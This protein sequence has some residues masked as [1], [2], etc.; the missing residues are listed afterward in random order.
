[1]TQLWLK[2]I[3][4]SGR[5]A[6]GDSDRVMTQRELEAGLAKGKI[7]NDAKSVAMIHCVG[8]RD[9]EHLYCSRTCCSETVKNALKVKELNPE[10]EVYCFYRDMRTY[11]KNEDYYRLAREKGVIFVRFDPER[12]PVISPNGKKLTVNFYDFIVGDDVEIEVDL[13]ALAEGAWP[14]VEGNK[15]LAEMLK[16]PLTADGFYLEAHMKLRPVD[17]ATEGV[18][19]CGLAHGPKNVEESI[20]QAQAAAARAITILAKDTI[21]AEGR[22]AQVNENRC[23]GCGTCVSICPYIAI[24]LDTDK[25]IAVVNEGLC[26]GCGS[27]AAACWSAAIDI[28]GV[29]NEQLLEAITAL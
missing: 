8:S 3:W 2:G 1:M 29:S 27:C 26:K 17:F 28:A 21:T 4:T 12:K 23:I 22:V 19:V 25:G 16:V 15:R 18:F 13:L 24:E 10:T 5:F 6:L 20:S 11:G 7:P 9:E 14:D